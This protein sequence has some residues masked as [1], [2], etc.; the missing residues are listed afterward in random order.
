MRP[1]RAFPDDFPTVDNPPVREVTGELSMLDAATV[2]MAPC[3]RCGTPTP[4]TSGG[5]TALAT[6]SR[7][8]AK[9]GE[10]PLDAAE[11]LFCDACAELRVKARAEYSAHQD[12]K[13]RLACERLSDPATPT[14]VLGENEAFV[15]KVAN[16][17]NDIVKHY[18]EVRRKASSRGKGI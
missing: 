12:V 3:R 2:R 18:A 5:E 11:C 6:W 10:A 15:R 7:I 4:L 17:G 9:R 14:H 1:E 8:L 13:L 16:F